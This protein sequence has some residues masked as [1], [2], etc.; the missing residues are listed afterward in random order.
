MAQEPLP[1]QGS[2]L[3]VKRLVVLDAVAHQARQLRRE[4]R[5]DQLLW[6][7]CWVGHHTFAHASMAA[8]ILPPLMMPIIS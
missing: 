1:T 2:T 5:D 8:G 4:A 7:P 6:Q 3:T